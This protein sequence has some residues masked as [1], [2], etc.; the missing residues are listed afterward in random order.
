MAFREDCN[1]LTTFENPHIVNFKVPLT[2]FHPHLPRMQLDVPATS[3]SI[4][5]TVLDLLVSSES[6][7]WD[8]QTLTN[9]LLDEYEGQSLLRSFKSH[10]DGKSA[11]RISVINAGAALLSIASATTPWRL[12]V[13]L[14]KIATPRFTNLETDPY[15]LNPL[16]VWHEPDFVRA[17]EQREGRGAVEWYHQASETAYQWAYEQK[18]RWKYTGASSQDD[19]APGRAADVG[20]IRHDHWWNT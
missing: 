16:E 2:F 5:P 13:P 12:V 4:L 17:L 8:D 9:A 7:G 6:L 1:A 18:V 14:C 15:E 10:E 3:L 11:W 19:K 20:R